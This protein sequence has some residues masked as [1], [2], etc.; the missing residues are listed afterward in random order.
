MAVTEQKT[1]PGVWGTGVPRAA[2][3]PLLV[4]GLGA[5][6]GVVNGVAGAVLVLGGF[7]WLAAL[8]LAVA[9]PVYVVF[10]PFV[11]AGLLVHHHH[12]A[13]S[14]AMAIVMAL[15]LLAKYREDD[16]RG[17]FRRFFPSAFRWPVALL[18][19]IAVVS[20]VH[21]ES[22][23]VAVIKILELVEFFVVVVAVGADLGTEVN[24]WKPTLIGLFGLTAYLALD[25]LEQFLF[26]LG[27]HSFAVFV[28]HIRAFG[29]F[30]Q[31]NVFGSF[32]AQTLPLALALYLFGPQ[33]RHRPWLLVILILDAFSVWSSISRGAW[34]SDIAAIGLMGL[35]VA[36]T[37]ERGVLASYAAYGVILP[38]V[39]FGAV[40]AL[41][42]VDLSHTALA[43][44][45]R[46]R[47]AVQRLL[48]I[49][50]T[51]EFDTHQRLLIWH[52]AL[53]AIRRHWT[54]GVGMGEFTLW[55][56]KHMP[57]GLTVV[58]PHAHDIYLELGADTGIL[59]IVAVVWLQ[60][61]WIRQS[62]RAVLGRLGRLN[63]F[64]Y[65]M[66]LGALGTFTAF[67]VQN[68]VDYMVD[69]GVIVPLLLAMGFVAALV[70]EGA[71]HPEHD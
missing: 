39:L 38:I 58:P 49:T 63:D 18:L 12:I 1:R 27:P 24:A 35:F 3:W 56:Q 69:H 26:G 64:T 50:N 60:Y 55:I 65:A 66:A 15:V 57:A 40:D 10:S 16:I 8:S 23:S 2:V 37:R 45:L 41:G 25:G 51:Q 29:P 4:I 20:L 11:S 36:A 21:A 9:L 30:G 62:V 6:V 33:G 71:R 7:V 19:F 70:K 32:M 67:I 53:T 47:T 54:T 31:P 68:W 42:H 43:N 46:G 5:V 61:Q 28:G 48:S 13:L 22:H 34:V 52:A 59:G 17:W 14:D 44:S